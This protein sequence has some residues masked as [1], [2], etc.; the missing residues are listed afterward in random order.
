MTP[1]GCFDENY[2]LF[3]CGYDCYILNKSHG[4]T[5]IELRLHGDFM[6]NGCESLYYQKYEL[7]HSRNIHLFNCKTNFYYNTVATLQ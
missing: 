7:T 2:L 1:V 6:D 3:M 5:S 4:I